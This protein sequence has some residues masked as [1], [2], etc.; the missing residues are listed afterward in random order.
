MA[1]TERP[2]LRGSSV[3]TRVLE[4]SDGAGRE[5]SD[6]LAGEEPLEIRAAGPGQQAVR[7]AV[8]M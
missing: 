5:R 4:V 2:P 3:D 8:T 6:R 7:V 1:A